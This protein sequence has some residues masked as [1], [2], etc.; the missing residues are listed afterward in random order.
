[1][2]AVLFV[3][4]IAVLA[5]LAAIASGFLHVNQTRSAKAPDVSATRNGVTAKGGQPPAFQV[6]TGSVQVG[7]RNQTVKVPEL[8]VTLPAN[9]TAPV[10]NTAG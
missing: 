4:I 8:R 2:R 5:L 10:N 7:S 3:V 1:M 9:Q 6:E